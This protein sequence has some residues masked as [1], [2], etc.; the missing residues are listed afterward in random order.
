MVGLRQKVEDQNVEAQ[1]V[2]STFGCQHFVTLDLF[3]DPRPNV[4]DLLVLSHCGDSK[5]KMV[6]CMLFASVRR[7]LC[8]FFSQHHY[9]F[10]QD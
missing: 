7:G 9:I 8:L 10:I 1:K 4:L 3:F 6:I 2:P 5:S